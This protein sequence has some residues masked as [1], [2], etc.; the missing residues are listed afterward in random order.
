MLDKPAGREMDVGQSVFLLCSK[1]AGVNI[2]R[3]IPDWVGL[4]RTGPVPPP[5]M[6]R[7]SFHWTRLYSF[8]Q[9]HLLGFFDGFLFVFSVLR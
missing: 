8:C 3:G 9:N 6:G 1:T 7:D 4:E 5:V 2:F